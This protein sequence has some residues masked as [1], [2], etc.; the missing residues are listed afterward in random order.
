MASPVLRAP[1]RPAARP[2]GSRGGH[3]PGP[4]GGASARQTG[5]DLDLDA[6]DTDHVSLGDEILFR[7]P[8]PGL[9]LNDEEIAIASLLLSTAAWARGES[10]PPY[11][12]ADA[13]QDH[14]V[15]LA[16]AEAAASGQLVTTATEAWAVTGGAPV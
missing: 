15:G 9:R 2:P 4:G 13:C 11:P 14:L 16:I 12:L 3:R 10:G 6:F 1:R 5:Y 7:N 8:F